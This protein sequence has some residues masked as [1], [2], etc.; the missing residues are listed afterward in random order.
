LC[1]AW[2]TI[3]EQHSWNGLIAQSA[4][5]LAI[6]SA[7]GHLTTDTCWSITLPYLR[8]FSIVSGKLA[9]TKMVSDSSDIIRTNFVKQ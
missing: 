8:W 4:A 5:C 9:Y 2:S 1:G 7:H 6:F 3:E